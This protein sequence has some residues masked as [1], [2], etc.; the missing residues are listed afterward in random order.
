MFIVETIQT[1]SSPRKR[2][3]TGRTADLYLLRSSI[4]SDTSE[5]VLFTTDPVH[6]SRIRLAT[7]VFRTSRLERLLPISRGFFLRKKSSKFGALC[8]MDNLI[9]S[10][11]MS[12]FVLT[13]RCII[14]CL[15][16]FHRKL[17]TISYASC[18][19]VRNVLSYQT[20]ILLENVWGY[21]T[22]LYIYEI[23][24]FPLMFSPKEGLYY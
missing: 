13:Q 10:S 5:R 2:T 9:E 22:K 15:K 20:E 1:A 3:V 4:D 7:G 11:C 6:K 18:T 16:C 14:I 12:G 8:V 19:I 23:C 17:H 21:P 24:A